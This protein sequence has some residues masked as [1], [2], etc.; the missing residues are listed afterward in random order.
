[1]GVGVALLCHEHLSKQYGSQ[2]LS[3]LF[4]LTVVPALLLICCGNGR[5]RYRGCMMFHLIVVAFV[6]SVLV[7][8]PNL[9]SSC[10]RT[11]RTTFEE[12]QLEME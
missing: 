8:L 3:I 2:W 11:Q 1:M 6:A 4:A 10:T 9:L 5:R 7:L 12:V